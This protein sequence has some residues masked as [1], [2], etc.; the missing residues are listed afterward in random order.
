MFPNVDVPEGKKGQWEIAR[1]TVSKAD[2][3]FDR[4]LNM[5][6]GSARHVSPGTYTRLIYG[7][8][9]TVMSD[10]P[11]EMRDHR[12]AV[13]QA[14]EGHVLIGG[15]GLGM[16]ANAILE[17]APE[18]RVTVL[19]ID[20][21]IIRL[22][23]PHYIDKFG[24]KRF[25]VIETDAMQWKPPKGVHYSVV[26]MDIWPDICTDNLADMATLNR[27]YARRS[28]WKGCWAQEICKHHKRQANQWS[29]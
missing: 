9:H 23:A 17:K 24:G 26:W 11:D 15:L 29:L 20:T 13:Y 5:F 4:I 14:R 2:S 12:E 6:Q 25:E 8:R 27:R 3:D 21:D 19:E 16:V 18:C 1:F 10:T 22:V 28:D 7:G